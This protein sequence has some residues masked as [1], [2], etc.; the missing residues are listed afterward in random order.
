MTFVFGEHG[1]VP[2]ERLEA[3]FVLECAQRQ[4]LTNGNV[5]PSLAHDDEAVRQTEIAFGPALEV[6]KNHVTSGREVVGKALRAAFERCGT[7]PSDN[8]TEPDGFLDTV[9]DD[10]GNLI[11][12]GWLVA[13]GAGPLTIELTSPGGARVVADRVE[14]PDV[15]AA[16]DGNAAVLHAGFSA[17]L[18][19][20][21]FLADGRWDLT[22]R[23]SRGDEAL[24][25]CRITRPRFTYAGVDLRPSSLGD[26]GILHL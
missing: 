9:R 10:G 2:H 8:A 16:Y 6:V 1:G 24:I 14:R 13:D 18:P 12:N 22:L 15:A 20:G 11:V 5:L 19:A 21:E 3:L 25:I 23:G 4:V 7:T 26:G 17:I